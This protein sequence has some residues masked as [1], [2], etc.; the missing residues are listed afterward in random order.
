MPTDPQTWRSPS[1]AL[2]GVIFRLVSRVAFRANGQGG[3]RAPHQQEPRHMEARKARAPLSLNVDA[4][5]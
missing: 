3:T 1:L 2:Y 5:R 4:G